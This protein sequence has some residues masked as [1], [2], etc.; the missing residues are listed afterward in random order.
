MLPNELITKIFLLST[1][2][3]FA[4]GFYK[5]MLV[6]KSFHEHLVGLQTVFLTTYF[7][8]RP[9]LLFFIEP[10]RS[11]VVRCASAEATVISLLRSH[12]AYWHE[13]TPKEIE[14]GRKEPDDGSRLSLPCNVGDYL[15]SSRGSAHRLVRLAVKHSKPDLVRYMFRELGAS[16]DQKHLYSFETKDMGRSN[17]LWQLDLSRDVDMLRLLVREFGL[18]VDSAYDGY[19]AVFDDYVRDDYA[20]EGESMDREV[21]WLMLEG[22]GPISTMLDFGDYEDEVHLLER[23]RDILLDMFCN[24]ER[25]VEHGGSTFHLPEQGTLLFL[26]LINRSYMHDDSNCVK[27]VKDVV[28]RGRSTWS[29]AHLFAVNN[30]LQR[31]LQVFNEDENLV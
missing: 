15:K 25:T 12:H 27:L 23:N 24:E 3:Y 29:E 20:L 4:E 28:R 17:P 1:D 30:N 9:D 8:T 21:L 16:V 19:T 26:K 14:Q 2:S 10:Y 11:W 31:V 5:L 7:K 22:G 6:N 13:K 18:D